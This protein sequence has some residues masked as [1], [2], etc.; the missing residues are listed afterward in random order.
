VAAFQIN[1]LATQSFSFWFDHSI[2]ARFNY[3]VPADG[4]AAGMFGISMAT[5][6]L[7][8][9]SASLPKRSIR[10]SAKR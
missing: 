3:A 10:N 7:P 4:V 2:V 5:F 8:T 1:V 9:L 6:L